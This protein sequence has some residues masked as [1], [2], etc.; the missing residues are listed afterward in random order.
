VPRR[1]GRRTNAGRRRHTRRRAQT[2]WDTDVPKCIS[3][4]AALSWGR[5][6]LGRIDEDFDRELL[7]WMQAGTYTRLADLDT[8]TIARKGGN[9]A[10]EIRNWATVMGAV[11]GT[12]GEVLFYEA[13]PQWLTGVAGVAFA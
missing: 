2:F 4:T 5:E 12:R 1:G 8:A 10:Q 7:A 6:G 11:P 3:S 13:V 9:G